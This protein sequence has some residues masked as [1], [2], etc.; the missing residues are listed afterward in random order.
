MV[1]THKT[2]KLLIGVDIGASKILVVAGNDKPEILRSQKIATPDNG[3]Q[4]V[5][6]ITHIIEQ[7]AGH[8]PIGAIYVASP[9]PI[10]RSNG[11]IMKTPNMSWE[12]LDIVK[13][14]HNHFRVPVGLEKDADAAALAEAKIGAGQGYE[15]VLYVT[16]STGVGI[17]LV[18]GGQLYH[19]AHDPEGGHIRIMAEGKSEELETAIAGPAL[20]RRF[21]QYGYEITDPKIWDEYAKDVATGLYDLIITLSPS[22]VVMGGGVNVHFHKFEAALHKHLSELKPIN[23]LPSIVPAKYMETAVAYGAL[24]LASNLKK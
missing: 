22:V 19:G 8:E 24:I 12:P 7:L 23:P 13:Q 3:P 20:K 21:G 17:G 16:I 14:L 15:T 18:T 10:D 6:E 5:I 1:S 2:D 9:G 11:V 4:A